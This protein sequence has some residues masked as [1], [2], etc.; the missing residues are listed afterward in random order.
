MQVLLKNFRIVDEETDTKGAIIIQNENILELMPDEPSPSGLDASIIIDGKDLSY[1][2]ELPVLMPAFIDLHAHFRDPGFPEKETLESASMAAAAGGFGTAI[3]MANTNPVTDTIE[4]AAGIK[5]RSGAIG[6]I[7]LYPVLSLTKGMEGRELSEITLLS[8]GSR[9]RPLLLSEDGKD[10]ADDDLFLAAMEEARR[11]GIPVSC[12]CDLGG[13]E[14]N[15]VGR[16]IDLG[17]KAGCRIHIAHVSTA[18]AVAAIRQAKAEIATASGG[19]N[20]TGG[21]SLTCEVTP[22][23]L[24]LTDS[25]AAKLGEKTWGALNP[26]LRPEKDR[27]ALIGALTDGTGTI[28]AIATDHAPHDKAGK[29]AG[30]PG[31]SGFETAFAAL[32]TTLLTGTN[33]AIGI[34]RLSAL[35]SANPARLL[36]FGNSRGRLL[37]G[38]KADLVIVD[39]GVSWTVDTDNFKS[40]GKNSPFKGQRLNGS[41]LMTIH[42]GRVVYAGH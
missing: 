27:L 40:R 42:N 21:F 34:K 31:F 29:E 7:D 25:D 13:D 22:H 30:A 38:S 37:S 18:E 2:G 4:L 12:H 32:Y 33:S 8:P 26:P 24:C 20:A 19:A 9:Y 36:G 14:N 11:N 15:A 6:L 1:S 10:L 39:T 17:K 5:A 35:M 28:D 23:H 41:V 16:A 3:C